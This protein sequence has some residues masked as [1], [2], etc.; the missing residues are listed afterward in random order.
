MDWLLLVDWLVDWLLS[1]DWLV[2]WLLSVDW[3]VDWLLSVDWVVD[4]LLSVDWL[5]DWLLGGLVG[6]FRCIKLCWVGKVKD[7]Q[8]EEVDYDY[9]LF[10]GYREINHGYLMTYSSSQVQQKRSSTLLSHSFVPASC[11]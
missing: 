9:L 1:V 8:F 4:W 3:L 2:D 11:A 10:I 5:V 7:N 6:C